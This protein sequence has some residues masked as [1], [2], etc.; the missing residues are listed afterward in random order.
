MPPTSSF[1]I[2]CRGNNFIRNTWPCMRW[3]RWSLMTHARGA[4]TL[5]IHSRPPAPCPL[6]YFNTTYCL[7]NRMATYT[8]AI[9][10]C[11]PA[12]SIIWI[13]WLQLKKRANFF[14]LVTFFYSNYNSKTR[15]LRYDSIQM[16]SHIKS[17]KMIGIWFS[18]YF[19]GGQPTCSTAD[20]FHIRSNF[21]PHTVQMLSF[22]RLISQ[23]GLK[24]YP[25]G[26][27]ITC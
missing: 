5:H 7:K 27:N 24:Y 20:N 3:P 13:Q 6:Q 10:A 4:A 22:R 19:L 23:F 9:F 16:S 11:G 26:W 1:K 21:T 17:A 12:Q 18:T 25:L 15:W 14:I 8:L 2:L